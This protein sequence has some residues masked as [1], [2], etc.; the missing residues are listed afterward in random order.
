MEHYTPPT[1]DKDIEGRIALF[2][3][4]KAR[5]CH[6]AKEEVDSH[7]RHMVEVQGIDQQDARKLLLLSMRLNGIK[8]ETYN[9][10]TYEW[11]QKEALK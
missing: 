8:I 7:I 9:P 6:I 4:L 11:T 2:K 3:Q 5:G 1:L 10:K